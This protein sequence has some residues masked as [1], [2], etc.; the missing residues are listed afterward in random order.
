MAAIRATPV[1][2]CAQD[3]AG[4]GYLAFS[5]A[6][7]LAPPGSIRGQK[8]L[9]QFPD[10]Y[11]DVHLEV[12]AARNASRANGQVGAVGGSAGAT[13]AVWTATTGQPGIDRLDVAV[14]LSGAYD[15]PDF[16]P[17]PDLDA[18]ITVV[19]NYVGVPSTDTAAP[20]YGFS[21]LGARCHGRAALSRG[22][23]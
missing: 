19:T 9:G 23:G 11:D 12:A 8:S 7:R 17:D 3:L 15:F 14:C 10:Q 21:G 2:S 4:A 18:F 13:H 20:A 22:V 16:R 1:V 6:Y 5:I